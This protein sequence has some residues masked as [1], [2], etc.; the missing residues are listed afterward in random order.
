MMWTDL[1]D[2]TTVVGAVAEAGAG[3]TSERLMRLRTKPRFELGFTC[4]LGFVDLT[5]CGSLRFKHE[6]NSTASPR[7]WEHLSPNVVPLMNGTSHTTSIFFSFNP[8]T[9]PFAA[10][11]TAPES[12]TIVILSPKENLCPCSLYIACEGLSTA[13]L[14]IPFTIAFLIALVDDLDAVNESASFS[15]S[16]TVSLERETGLKSLWTLTRI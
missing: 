2:A 8:N 12:I 11:G 6:L 3:R 15:I 9:T 4:V 16:D 10:N 14:G 13:C 7:Y 1:F 5:N